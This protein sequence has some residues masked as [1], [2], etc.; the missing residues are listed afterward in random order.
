MTNRLLAPKYLAHDR[1]V[2]LHAVVQPSPGLT[3]PA[4]DDLRPRHAQPGDEA[5]TSSER[6]DGC[7]AH[8]RIC[9]SPCGK[10]H[11]TRAEPDTLRMRRD[12][13]KRTDRIG[14]VSLRTPNRVIPQ[15]LGPDDA[16]GR[17]AETRPRIANRQPKLHRFAPL[18]LSVPRRQHAKARGCSARDRNR[19]P[20]RANVPFPPRPAPAHR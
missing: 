18:R 15:F 20:G 19:R 6:V 3:I 17:Q 4:L 8:C 5:I 10:L 13:R 12:K 9:R 16:F 11:H 1:H 2:V 14:T 7:G